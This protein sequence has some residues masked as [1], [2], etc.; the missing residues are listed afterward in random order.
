MTAARWYA[1]KGLG[2]IARW[3][4]KFAGLCEA[5]AVELRYPEIRR[6]RK[7]RERGTT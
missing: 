3:A 5:W 4:L 1:V 2:A 7:Q 6:K